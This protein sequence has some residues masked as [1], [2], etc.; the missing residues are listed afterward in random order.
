MYGR[1][2][3]D[4]IFGVTA[5]TTH[6]QS[7]WCEDFDMMADM[8]L[9]TYRLGLDWSRIEPHPGVFDDDAVSKYREMLEYLIERGIKPL[10]TL[11]DFSLPCKLKCG[12]GKPESI[13]VF[14]RYVRFAADRFGDLVDDWITI[15]NPN[16]Y[17]TKNFPFT[18]L[19]YKHLTMA[20]IK[21]YKTI[22]EA[23]PNARV[24]AAFNLRAFSP[25]NPLNPADI[26]AAKLMKY[27]FQDAIIECMATGKLVSPIGH[28]SPYCKGCYQDFIGVNYYTRPT[29]KAKGGIC[30]TEREAYPK[31][32]YKLCKE[33]YKKYQTPIYIT[34]NGIRDSSDHQRAD[35]I[36]D[37]L[38]QAAKLINDG[39]DVRRYYHRA[40]TGDF[41]LAAVDFETQKHTLRPSGWLYSLIAKTH[42]LP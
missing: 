19:V 22:H 11:L 40:L 37:H 42:K 23:C 10:V 29:V 34:E 12:F 39:V 6:H 3:R 26:A 8:G 18:M 30:E 28:S 17:T 16:T 35:F 25:Y 7:H 33:I 31:G 36:V 32:L 4:F 41:G 5:D 9:D 13:A 15:S 24:G 1:F 2:P 20:H 38:Y 21:A 14:E 27:L